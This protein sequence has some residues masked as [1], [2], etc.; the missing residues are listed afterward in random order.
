MSSKIHEKNILALRVYGKTGVKSGKQS[1][2]P[3][4]RMFKKRYRNNDIY[5]SICQSLNKYDHPIIVKT[6]IFDNC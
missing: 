5:A 1:S 3:Q 4:K 2:W 6:A